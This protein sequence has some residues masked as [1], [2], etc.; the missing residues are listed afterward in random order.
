M[1]HFLAG[2]APFRHWYITTLTQIEEKIQIFSSYLTYQ[3][4]NGALP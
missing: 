2:I 3:S 1:E 4:L